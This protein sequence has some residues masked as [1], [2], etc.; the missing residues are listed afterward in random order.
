MLVLLIL[1]LK[2]PTPSAPN[3]ENFNASSSPTNLDQVLGEHFFSTDDEIEDEEEITH[4]SHSELT[5]VIST[6]AADHQLPRLH[7]W[8]K[9]HPPNQII[10]DIS[11]GVQTRSSSDLEKRCMFT[12][13]M[14]LTEPKKINEA[15]L[16][17]DWVTAMQEELAEFGRN[18]VWKLV[19]IP[20][21][22]TIIGTRWVFR[23]KLVHGR[24][25]PAE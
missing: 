17:H 15:L 19:P 4:E 11:K 23:N 25:R 21:G 14:S 2:G 12:A 1:G 6:A 22:H 5:N 18:K 3:Q 24:W 13:F 9:D 7:I 8:T 20:K 10:G 16:D